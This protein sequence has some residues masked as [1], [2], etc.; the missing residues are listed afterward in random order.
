MKRYV[1]HAAHARLIARTLGMR[2]A[3]GYLRNR[4]FNGPSAC[5]VLLG[6]LPRHPGMWS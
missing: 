3:A 6:R 5:L 1:S 4:G 2:R